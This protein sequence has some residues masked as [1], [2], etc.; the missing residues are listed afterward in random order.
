MKRF[1]R[2]EKKRK[3]KLIENDIIGNYNTCIGF[4]TL[5]LAVFLENVFILFL[6][7]EISVPR[8]FL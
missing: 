6:L 5:K 7:S 8:P 1:V 3:Y 4:R 2:V